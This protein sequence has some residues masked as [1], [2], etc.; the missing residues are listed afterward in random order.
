M[1]DKDTKRKEAVERQGVYNASSYKSK[2]RTIARRPGES[3]KEL[4]RL[5]DRRAAAAHHALTGE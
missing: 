4:A 3:K 5:Q 2:L 1:K